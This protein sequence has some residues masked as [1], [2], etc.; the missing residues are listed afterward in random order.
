M[1]DVSWSELLIVAAVALVAVGPKEMPKAMY[2]LGR[3]AGKAR[4][5]VRDFAR[6]FEQ[7]S[8]EAALQDKIDK[9]KIPRSE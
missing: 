9:L 1:L 2:A 3:W 5:G 6:A 8:H 4:R 7:V